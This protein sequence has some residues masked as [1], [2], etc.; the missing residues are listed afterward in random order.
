MEVEVVVGSVDLSR[1]GKDWTQGGDGMGADWHRAAAEGQ[2]L[3]V[4]RPG[5]THSWLLFLSYPNL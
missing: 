2:V 1:W 5:S 3:L 4:A